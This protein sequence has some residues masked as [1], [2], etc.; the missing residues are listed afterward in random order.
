MSSIIIGCSWHL[1][2]WKVVTITYIF[3]NFLNLLIGKDHFHLT[4]YTVFVAAKDLIGLN[5]F[6]CFIYEQTYFRKS[7]HFWN[8]VK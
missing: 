5:G 7:N 2:G 3:L 1:F 8:V 6:I 4:N